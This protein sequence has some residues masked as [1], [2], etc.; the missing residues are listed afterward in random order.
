MELDGDSELWTKGGENVVDSNSGPVEE[1]EGEDESDED[2]GEEAVEKP[3]RKRRY[4]EDGGPKLNRA[5]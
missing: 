3:G 2:D 5:G 1:V 4:V